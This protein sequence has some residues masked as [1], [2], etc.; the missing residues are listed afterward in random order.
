[1]AFVISVGFLAQRGG[2]LACARASTTPDRCLK[3]VRTL[4]YAAE[5]R[6]RADL[7]AAQLAWSELKTMPLSIVVECLGAV[8]LALCERERKATASRRVVLDLAGVYRRECLEIARQ[9]VEKGGLERDVYSVGPD[10]LGCWFAFGTIGR[11]GD[12]SDI[13]ILRRRAS[14]HA[15]TTYAMDALRSLDGRGAGNDD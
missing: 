7:A 11:Y 13:G 15:C 4:L 10:K 3:A 5:L 6:Q 8:Q 1:M 9:F 12:R 14:D 2:R